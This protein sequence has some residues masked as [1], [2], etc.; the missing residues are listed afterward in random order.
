LFLIVTENTMYTGKELHGAT[1]EGPAP[2]PVGYHDLDDLAPA[3]PD[4]VPQPPT[5][6]AIRWATWPAWARSGSGRGAHDETAPAVRPLVKDNRGDA[7]VDFAIGT[8]FDGLVV[9]KIAHQVITDLHAW[10]R[11]H[12]TQGGLLGQGQSAPRPAA[13]PL[14]A[15]RSEHC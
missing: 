3:P 8:D 10:P 6:P 13:W 15:G 14:A 1:A 12:P 5:I 9:I 7:T 4:Q 11:Q 2:T